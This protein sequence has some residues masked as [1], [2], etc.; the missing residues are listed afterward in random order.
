MLRNTL[1]KNSRAV[2]YDNEGDEDIAVFRS[3]CFAKVHHRVD[4]AVAEIRHGHHVALRGWF[5]FDKTHSSE[6]L[7]EDS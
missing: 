5:S 2:T 1:K 4:V 3:K 6:T 7:T